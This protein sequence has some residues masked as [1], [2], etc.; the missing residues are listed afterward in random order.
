MVSK[1]NL[2]S[3]LRSTTREHWSDS[4]YWLLYAAVGS[5]FPILVGVLLQRFIVR[6][7]EWN[8]FTRHGEFALY[9]AGLLA[10]AFRLVLRDPGE[11][12][13]V[14]RQLFGLMA[15]AGLFIAAV[16]YSGVTAVID[17]SKTPILPD[18]EFLRDTTLVLFGLSVTFAFLVTLLDNQRLQPPVEALAMQKQKELEKQ[19][20][21]LGGE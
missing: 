2:V 11:A 6:H 21:Q 9:S 8:D 18:M 7:I 16:L 13:F 17:L 12:P 15:T 3:A 10:S 19:F 4:G 14:H 5:L 20:D 1:P